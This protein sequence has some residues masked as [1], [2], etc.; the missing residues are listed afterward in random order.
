MTEFCLTGK[1]EQAVT[2]PARALTVVAG[3]GTGK[4]EVVARR[5]ERLL[6]Q[7]PGEDFR[8]LAVSYTVRA[9][10]GLRERLAS[11]LRDLHRRV[12]ADTIH[13]FALSVVRRHGT[14]IGLPLE[15]EIL[16]R[17]ED[18][19]ELLSAWLRRGGYGQPLDPAETFRELDLYRARENETRR[20]EIWRRVLAEAG[21]LDY[22][23]MLER[24]TELLSMRSVR[25]IYASLYKHVIVDEAQNLTKSQYRL[26]SSLIG[27]P[28]SDHLAAM[29]VGDERQSIVGFAG[30]DHTLMALFEREYSAERV[31]LVTNFRSAQR[32]DR[33]ARRVA[34]ALD[35]P[36]E[37]C[38]TSLAARGELRLEEFESEAAE[39]TG[40]A[41]WVEKQLSDGLPDDAVS[42]DE[43]TSVASEQIAVL[44][45]S[46]AALIPT[47]EA[48]DKLDIAHASAS[49]PD[50]W[51]TSPPA[52]AIVE[53]IGFKSAPDHLSGRRR[54]SRL[55]GSEDDEGWTEVS[56]LFRQSADPDLAA[57]A[58]LGAVASPEELISALSELDISDPD[59]LDDVE[60]INDSWTSFIDRVPAGSQSFAELKHHIARCQR[61]D[62]LD[63]GVRLLTVHKAQGHEFRS[64][65]VVACNEGQFPDFRA[66]TPEAE[67]AERRTF[68][69]A[70][71]RPFRSL[72]VSRALTRRT[73]YGRRPTSPSRF[74]EWVRN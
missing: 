18:R 6:A 10:D 68:Y 60:Q 17:D 33:V 61:G 72:L 46:A 36:L 65:A 71:S 64:V 38:G 62:P 45:R 16:S 41:S 49:T 14:L 23:A 56:E 42:P 63:P 57:L 21:A 7:S 40:V 70:V 66:D 30:A 2:S 8:V 11:R 32:I 12:D 26:L 31:E 58:Q 69:V 3:A 15:P 43:S 67:E 25:R 74:L 44:S 50:A 1:Q 54:L 51:V 29:L 20:V 55:C 19:R 5:L 34:A 48:L 4:T 73:R 35:L 52:Q 47:R 39:G 24:A 59:W 27:S 53:L 13:G 37:V 28:G 9:A 22:Q